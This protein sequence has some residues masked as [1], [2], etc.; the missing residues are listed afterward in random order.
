LLLIINTFASA[1]TAEDIIA[2]H[3]SAIGGDH[4][5]NVKSI[6]MQANITADAA[7]GMAILWTMTAVRD[8][9]ARMDVSV[10]GMTQ[11]SV[12]NGDKGWSNNPFMGKTDPEPMTADQVKSMTSMTDIDGAIVGYK[13]KGYTVEYVGTEDVDGTEAL[14]I[15]INKGDNKVEYSLYD[16]TTYYEIKNIQVEVVDGKEVETATV[17]SN[18]KTQ[19]NIVFPFTMQQANPMM[20]NSTITVTEITVNP[21]VDDKIFDMPEKK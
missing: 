15:K 3:L 11:T 8:K 9:A 2:K 13:E 12:V 18:Y 7:A 6:K 21:V 19:D 4:W 20:G 14:K 5:K 17:Y 16:P 1:Q 10:M